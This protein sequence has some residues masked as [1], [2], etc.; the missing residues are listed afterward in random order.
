VS[1]KR[2]YAALAR[3][4]RDIK[5]YMAWRSTV[6]SDRSDTEGSRWG[7]AVFMTM[8][9]IGDRDKDLS[10]ALWNESSRVG[11]VHHVA[12]S[13]WDMALQSGP[14]PQ[15]GTLSHVQTLAA[16]LMRA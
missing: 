6:E 10:T 8:A 11:K 7:S 3:I 15:P 1:G 5:E 14:S 9:A 12:L 4:K 16:D 2:L 13:Q